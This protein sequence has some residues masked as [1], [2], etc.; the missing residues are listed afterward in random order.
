METVVIQSSSQVGKTELLLNVIGYF[1]HQDP[2]P[3]LCIEPTLDIAEAYSKDRLAPMIRDTPVLFDIVGEA[4]SKDGSNTLLHKNFPGGHITLGG[5]NSPSGLA[6]RPVR[7]V[8]C[9]EV[10]RYPISAGAEGDPLSLASKRAANFWNR[11]K[12]FTSSPTIKDLSRIEAWFQSSDRRYYHVP[13]RACGQFQKLEWEYVRWESGR[14]DTA[15]YVCAFC[16]AAWNDAERHEAVMNGRWVA[17]A[18]FNGVAGF[19]IWE[20]YSPW[21]RLC[22]IVENFLSAK[23]AADMGDNEPL[24][25]FVNTSLGKT[26]EEKAESVNAAPLLDRR[27]SY[28][29]DRLPWQILY[30]TAGIDLQD[31]RIEVE[32]VGWRAE[33]RGDPEESWGIE[34]RLLY[35]DPAKPEIWQELDELLQKFFPTED[36]RNLRIS[37]AAVDS[38]GHHTA[39]VYRF[40]DRRVG[41]HIYA[42]KG[43][44]GARPI[45]PKRAGKSKKHAGSLIWLLGV[46]TAKDAI[47]ARLRIDKAGPG[48]CHFPIDYDES[49][50]AQ[51]T[52]EKVRTRYRKGHPIREWHKPPGARNEALDLRVYALAALNSRPVPWEI[53]ARS[54]PTEHP[55]IDPVPEKAIAPKPARPRPSAVARNV[56]FKFRK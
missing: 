25:A 19:H 21:S 31:D 49:Y 56:R 23:R 53:L 37:A 44:A 30:L 20:A 15:I 48:Y 50:F 52:A 12:I 41:R 10:D 47:Y 28:S 36:G 26:W 38:G 16:G 34:H 7:I 51:L 54:A 33:K 39:S 43:A 42:I 9:D 29:C 11:K 32:I 8:L 17:E 55:P 35:G 46:D 40:C 24:K 45:W 4:R 6:S 2:C 22:D 14:S 5:A 3:I 18:P 1:A 13:C 27:E